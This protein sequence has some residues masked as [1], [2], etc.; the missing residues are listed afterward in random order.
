[1]SN[2]DPYDVLGIQHGCTWGEVKKAYKNMCIRTHPDR[3]NGDAKY[4]MMVHDAFNKLQDRHNEAKKYR[5]LPK[6]K[7]NYDP[8]VTM[9]A[10]NVTPQK[11]KNYSPERFNAYFAQHKIADSDPFANNGYGSFMISSSKQREDIEYARSQKVYIPKTELVIH[12]TP[13]CLNS[14]KAF[15]SCYQLGNTEIQDYS[16]GGGTDIMVAYAHNPRLIDT[17]VRYSSIDDINSQRSKENLT[18]TAHERKFY[19]KQ[20]QEKQKLEQYRLN[21]MNNESSRVANEYIKL[22]RRLS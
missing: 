4:F 1:M 22:H 8:N 13:E 5:N 17:Q 7:S 21:N 9:Y 20:E 16:G 19:A 18:M 12:K 15:D 2:L 14:S 3:M 11:M 6:E 10:D